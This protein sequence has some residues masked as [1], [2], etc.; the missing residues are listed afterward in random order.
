M[1]AQ[2]RSMCIMYVYGDHVM[3][4]NNYNNNNNNNEFLMRFA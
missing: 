3:S 4:N 2:V 1:L